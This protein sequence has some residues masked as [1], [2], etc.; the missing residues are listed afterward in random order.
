MPRV[1]FTLDTEVLTHLDALCQRERRLRAQMLTY[2]IENWGRLSST[3]MTENISAKA[4]EPGQAQQAGGK[5]K[6]PTRPVGR[7]TREEYERDQAERLARFDKKTWEAAWDNEH[8]CWV[9]YKVENI[10]DEM[11]PVE[12]E[13]HANRYSKPWGEEGRRPV[14]DFIEYKHEH[15]GLI[16]AGQGDQWDGYRRDKMVRFDTREELLAFFNKR[17]PD[18]AI[19]V[20]ADGYDIEALGLQ[21]I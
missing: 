20:H 15:A 5:A 7:P 9:P 2:M 19:H 8:E 14:A 13:V 11:V 4:S 21:L 18:A 1:T 17:W 12:C 10:C 6:A 16:V 3:T